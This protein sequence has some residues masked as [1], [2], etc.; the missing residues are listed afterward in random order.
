M[1]EFIVDTIP[2]SEARH[3]I[4]EHHYSKG[5][6]NGAS[7]CF[8]LW[9]MSSIL[10]GVL[11]F[12]TPCS[13]N[14]R[15]SVF[16]VT[17]KDAVLELHRLVI[18]DCTPSNTESA[19][20]SCCLRELRK[21]RKEIQAVVSFADPSA[22]HR[23]VIYQACNFWYYGR[24][25]AAT[26]WKDQTGRLRHPRQNGRNVSKEE[27]VRRGWI[28]ERRAGKHRYVFLYDRKAIADCILPITKEYPK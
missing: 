18:L 21:L 19:F 10:L 9:S 24:T 13:E 28:A 17:R 8:G 20:V 25:S 5:C 15:R 3:F 14:V 23:G 12:A 1:T 7:P 11:M 6:H 2:Y 26:F 27:T 22:G 4:I 16:G